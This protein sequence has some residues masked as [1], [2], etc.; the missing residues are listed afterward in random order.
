MKTDTWELRLGDGNRRLVGREFVCEQC[1]VAF[2]AYARPSRTRRFCS[3]AC[4]CAHVQPQLHAKTGP[5]HAGWLGDSVSTRGGRSRALRRYP[6]VGPCS[7][8]GAG[9]AERHHKDENTANNEPSNIA[10]LCRRCHMETDGRL[11][12]AP[13][14]MRAVQPLGV[15]AR[16]S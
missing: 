8:C 4:R 13:A 12:S 11:A 15:V 1:S 16:W 6:S 2:C 5:N 10:I 9:K 14:R 7:R 3:R